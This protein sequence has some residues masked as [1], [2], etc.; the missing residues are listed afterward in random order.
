MS[1]NLTVTD[2]ER[3]EVIEVYCER[4]DAEIAAM[5]TPT[6]TGDSWMEEHMGMKLIE[7]FAN[8]QYISGNMR[9]EIKVFLRDESFQNKLHLIGI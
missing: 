7:V 5:L 4:T 9:Y 3:S 8:R 2:L 6:P 1:Y